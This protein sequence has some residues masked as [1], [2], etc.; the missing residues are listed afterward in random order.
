M[1][2][3]E[4]VRKTACLTHDGVMEWVVIRFKLC[5]TPSTFKLMMN[6]ILRE[7]LHRLVPVYL[8]DVLAYKR[9]L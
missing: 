9:T 2:D 8:D 6:G 4:D 3:E 1:R 7:F 5:N